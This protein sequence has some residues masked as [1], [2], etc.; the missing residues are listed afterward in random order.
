MIII[1]IDYIYGVKII[2]QVRSQMNFF[3]INSNVI[4]H[5]INTYDE[6]NGLSLS[7]P[8]P[9]SIRWDGTLETR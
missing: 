8:P 2:H 4:I 5:K 3:H 7:L 6:W 9:L 1:I